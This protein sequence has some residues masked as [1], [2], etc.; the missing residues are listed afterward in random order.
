[1]CWDSKKTTSEKMSSFVS[2][3]WTFAPKL[4]A[5]GTQLGGTGNVTS[6]VAAGKEEKKKKVISSDHIQDGLM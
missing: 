5:N 6:A 2:T 4:L 1:M 3:H